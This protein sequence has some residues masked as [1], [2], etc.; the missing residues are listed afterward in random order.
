MVADDEIVEKAAA[1][2]RVQIIFRET[3]F[4][5]EMGGQVA[6]KGTIETEMGEVI[7][8]IEDVKRAPNG[9]TMHIARILT[10]IHSNETYV[11]HVDEAR[12]RNITKNPIQRRICLHQALKDVLGNHANQAGS[13][14]NPNQ[15][16]F[17][18]THFG[19]VT[20]YHQKSWCGWKKS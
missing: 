8:E 1:D 2:D 11:L 13:L 5:A 9:Q 16:R 17:D 7:A 19:Q 10:E 14:V 15:L 3:P 6:D 18:F 4:Y 20:A 12:R